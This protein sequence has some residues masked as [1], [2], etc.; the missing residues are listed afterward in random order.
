MANRIT[1]QILSELLEGEVYD[2]DAEERLFS[3]QHS[4]HALARRPDMQMSPVTKQAKTAVFLN[5]N[6]ISEHLDVVIEADRI[7]EK[8]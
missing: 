5:K 7:R 8:R 6:F 1:L 3:C 2:T 4:A